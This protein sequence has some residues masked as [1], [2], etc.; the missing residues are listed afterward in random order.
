MVAVQGQLDAHAKD[1]AHPPTA[2]L[3]SAADAFGK[4]L[5]SLRVDHGHEAPSLA[6]IG[7]QLATLATDVEGADRLPTGA[8]KALLAECL[9]R[10]D[11]SIERWSALRGQELA[12]LN[13]QFVA[14]GMAPITVP[15][16]AQIG[17]GGDAESKDLP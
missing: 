6:T 10:L 14:E 16:P 11:R 15:S 1:L 12:T 3:K 13:A 4:Q 5:E 17:P 2:K 9:S 8:Q 7:D